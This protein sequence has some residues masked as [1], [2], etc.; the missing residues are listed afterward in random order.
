MHP[1]SISLLAARDREDTASPLFAAID[2]AATR[3]ESA[4]R[5][6]A[7][8]ATPEERAIWRAALERAL[9][10]GERLAGVGAL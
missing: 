6:L 10:D 5:A 1:L 4:A 3:I 9:A 7:D 2:L 8:S